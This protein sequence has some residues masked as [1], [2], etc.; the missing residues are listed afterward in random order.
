MSTDSTELAFVRCPSC[1]SLVP[2]VSTRC[3]MCGETLDPSQK[4]EDGSGEAMKSGRVRQRTTASSSSDLSATAGLIRQEM[5]GG[6]RGAV[7]EAAPESAEQLPEPAEL[8]DED[9][10]EL[11]ASQSHA[12]SPGTMEPTTSEGGTSNDEDPLSAYIQ[13]VELE[14]DPRAPSGGSNGHAQASSAAPEKSQEA[15]KQRVIVES[16]PRRNK[17]SGLSFGGPKRKDEGE[18]EWKPV[19]DKQRQGKEHQGREPQGKESSARDSSARPD[20]RRSSGSERRESRDDR[21]G[22]QRGQEQT[23][24]PDSARQERGMNERTSAESTAGNRG[25][26]ERPGRDMMRN[27]QRGDQSRRSDSIEFTQPGTGKLVGWLVNY[28]DP[29]GTASELREGRFFVT[30]SSLKPTDFVLNEPSVSTPH[31]LIAA[32]TH[33]GLRVQD[34]MSDRGVWLKKRSHESYQRVNDSAKVDHGDWLRFGEVEFLVCLVG[35]TANK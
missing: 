7:Q 25:Q 4:P 20:E 28:S 9:A 21:R 6:K 15:S 31:A 12:Q 5:E 18:D 16:G 14:V 33:E 27:D 22:P 26:A 24:R 2:A 3:R 8:A 13:E 30:A 35:G 1:R 34:L 32:G 19:G 10:S 17:S 29:K 11:E 23:N